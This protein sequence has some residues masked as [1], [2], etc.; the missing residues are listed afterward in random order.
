FR[1]GSMKA[2]LF[3]K[4]LL[5]LKYILII[6]LSNGT[7]CLKLII[8]IKKVRCDY[9]VYAFLAGTVVLYAVVTKHVLNRVG[10]TK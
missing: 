1:T 2:P 6:I 3:E 7:M 8:I 5:F 9:M 10:A 4:E